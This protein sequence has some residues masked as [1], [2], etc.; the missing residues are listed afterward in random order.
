MNVKRLAMAFVIALAIS[1]LCTWLLGRKISGTQAANRIPDRN[2]VAAGKPMLAGEVFKAEDLQIVPW[3]ADQPLTGAFVKPEDVVGRSVLYPIDKGQP[4]TE[5]F[6]SAPGSGLGLSARIPNG[7]RAIALKSDEI[8]G[9]AGFIL[10]GSHLDVVATYRGERSPDPITFT[11]LQDAEVLAVGQKSQPD[12]DGKPATATVVTLLLT[13]EDA[14]RAVLASQQGAFHFV[15]RS[16]SDKE[17]VRT[18]PITIGKLSGELASPPPS[19]GSRMLPV[20]HVPLPATITVET[21]SG[22]KQTSDTFNGGR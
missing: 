2:Y 20:H 4:V 14:E 3:H 17:Q 21:I 22:D 10:P 1:A 5:K 18:A 9:V 6:L 16:G 12:P 7:M 8:M 15:L 11:V 19:G 13:P